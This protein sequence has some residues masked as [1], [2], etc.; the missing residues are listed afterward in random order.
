[1]VAV[2]NGPVVA[3]IA[4]RPGDELM[5]MTR[6]GQAVRTKTD[7]IRT[8]G[9]AAQG[10]TIIRLDEGDT[11]TGVAQCPRDEDVVAGDTKPDTPAT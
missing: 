3:S 5:I 10:V 9:R 6:Q 8:T 4:V 11:V 2:A 7:D 1:M